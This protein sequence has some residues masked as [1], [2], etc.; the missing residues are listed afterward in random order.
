MSHPEIFGGNQLFLPDM[1]IFFLY[2]KS[3]NLAVI[4][5]KN[6]NVTYL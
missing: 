1:A 3:L 6:P 4:F 2:H 5:F